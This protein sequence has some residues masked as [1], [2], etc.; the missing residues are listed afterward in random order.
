VLVTCDDDNV[1][2]IKAIEKNGGILE[3]VVTAPELDRPK[4]RYWFELGDAADR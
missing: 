3:N 4:R 1:G 2:S